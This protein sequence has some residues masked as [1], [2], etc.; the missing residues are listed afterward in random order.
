M[1]QYGHAAD[2]HLAPRDADPLETQPVVVLH[3]Q[4]P[5]RPGVWHRSL[6]VDDAFVQQGCQPAA[7][8]RC[9]AGGPT[10]I[11]VGVIRAAAGSWFD[12]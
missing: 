5:P 11:T 8:A 9:A 4:K 2:G 12:G 7:G 6:R 1:R 3:K 10:A